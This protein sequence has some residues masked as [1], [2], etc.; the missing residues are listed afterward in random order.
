M[1]SPAELTEA[2]RQQGLKLTPQRQLLFRLLHGNAVHPSADVLHAQASELMPGISLRTIYHTLND[3]AAMGELQL[4]S[5]GSGPARFDPNT[6]DHHHAVCAECGDVVDV[7][8]NNLAELQV[9][10]L[11]GFRPDSARLVFSGT[12]RHC[13]S[14]K[15][16]PQAIQQGIKEQS[17]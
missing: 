4:V 5:V 6:D 10:G 8:V 14:N 13:T 2:F 3:L 1:R 16:T 7:Y 15:S 9:D 11:N 12:C 17:S